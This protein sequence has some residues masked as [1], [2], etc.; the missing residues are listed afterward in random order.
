[1]STPVKKTPSMQG[2]VCASYSL[3]A[4]SPK[5]ENQR[6]VHGQNVGPPL[7]QV[8]A[9]ADQPLQFIEKRQ[10]D[11]IKPFCLRLRV[12][13]TISCDLYSIFLNGLPLSISVSAQRVGKLS[14]DD[15][16]VSVAEMGN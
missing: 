6:L 4:S 14:A 8:F 9:F 2:K 7:F 5:L 11:L 1:M 16:F 12:H 3:A 10:K 13:V 15:L